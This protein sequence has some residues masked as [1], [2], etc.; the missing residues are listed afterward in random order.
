AFKRP[1]AFRQCLSRSPPSRRAQCDLGNPGG[2]FASVSLTPVPL[3]GSGW[4][5]GK[6]HSDSDA[7]QRGFPMRDGW[8]TSSGQIIPM[9][10][11]AAQVAADK[12][13]KDAKATGGGRMATWLAREHSEIWINMQVVDRYP[14]GVGSFGI[15][16]ILPGDLCEF[17]SYG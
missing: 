8:Q 5:G 14:A 4:R 6:P 12:T 3:C 13:A 1:L 15:A 16:Q 17:F 9:V 11:T 2:R 10:P 7:E